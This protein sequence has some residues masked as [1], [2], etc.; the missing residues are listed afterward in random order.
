[1]DAEDLTRSIN[2]AIHTPHASGLFSDNERHVHKI[3]RGADINVSFSTQCYPNVANDLLF[4][5]HSTSELV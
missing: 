5:S 3:F 1:M 2:A 4:P